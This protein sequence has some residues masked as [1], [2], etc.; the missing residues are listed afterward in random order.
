VSKKPTVTQPTPSQSCFNVPVVDATWFLFT[1]VWDCYGI[2][3]LFTKTE[4]DMRSGRI[5][6]F[7]DSHRWSTSCSDGRISSCIGKCELPIMHRLR[8]SNPSHCLVQPSGNIWVLQTEGEHL[9]HVCFSM[10]LKRASESRLQK[11]DIFLLLASTCTRSHS[12]FRK[13]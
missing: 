2:T 4:L 12:P 10:T 9:Y 1:H 7:E 13:V 11:G 6:I 8:K 3:V 5:H